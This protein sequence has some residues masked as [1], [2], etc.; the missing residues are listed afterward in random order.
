MEIPRHWRMKKQRYGLVGEECNNCH[1]KI[2][3]PRDI[4]P[5][6]KTNLGPF[7]PDLS[8]AAVR[9]IS[10]GNK[11]VKGAEG[12]WESFLAGVVAVTK[13]GTELLPDELLRLFAADG[14]SKILDQN[15]FFEGVQSKRKI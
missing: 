11:P 14:G 12:Y 7:D 6:C 2:F 5:E 1:D 10:K 4:C 8:L 3:P 13:Y 9:E 15:R